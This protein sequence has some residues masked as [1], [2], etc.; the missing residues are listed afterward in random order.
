MVF[1]ETINLHSITLQD[2]RSLKYATL[3]VKFGEKQVDKVCINNKLDRRIK[4]QEPII[5]RCIEEFNQFKFEN[6]NNNHI[7]SEKQWEL[8]QRQQEL[9]N[10]KQR[11]LNPEEKKKNQEHA[12]FIEF[13]Q[14]EM[15]KIERE[16]AKREQNHK[17]DERRNS[18]LP[19]IPE[20]KTTDV[21]RMNSSFSAAQMTPV[22]K[23]PKI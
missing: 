17:K 22:P 12:R 1:D 10:D 8:E 2:K 9:E 6:K 16:L 23:L 21:R 5:Q 14:K 15:I 7:L 13:L 19:T 11:P 3:M 18:F 20:K 4:E